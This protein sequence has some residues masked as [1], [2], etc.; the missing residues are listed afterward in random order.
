MRIILNAAD[1]ANRSRTETALRNI[2]SA[3][4]TQMVHVAPGD[5]IDV[6]NEDSYLNWGTLGNPSVLI[7][8][9]RNIA[10]VNVVG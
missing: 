4:S 5:V 6:Q 10:I 7:R 2:P 3:V 9:S 8:P 1:D